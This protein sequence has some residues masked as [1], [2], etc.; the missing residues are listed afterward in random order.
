MT[1]IASIRAAIRQHPEYVRRTLRLKLGRS[2][3]QALIAGLM[4]EGVEVEM[5]WPHRMPLRF[6]DAIIVTTD[7]FPGW[8]LERV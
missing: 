7:H 5:S 4:C 1:A 8:T 2:A 3:G 6:E